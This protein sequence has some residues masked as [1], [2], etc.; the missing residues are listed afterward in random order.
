MTERKNLTIIQLK[1]IEKIGD[2][3]IP[4]L[5]FKAKDGETEHWYQCWRTSLF[6]A[7]K[8]GEMIDAE[9]E[10]KETEEY[11]TNRKIVQ[12]YVDGQPLGG[13]KVGQ[14]YR[15]KSPEELE[16]S[17]KSYALA[18][19]KDLAVSGTIKLDEIIKQSNVF[20]NWLKGNGDKPTETKQSKKVKPEEPKTE[21]EN[22]ESID[23]KALE[24]K[25]PGEFYQA[26]L[27]HLKLAKSKVD[28]EVPE[29]DLTNPDQCQKAWQQILAIYGH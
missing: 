29:Y 2:K 24:F 12:I 11:G 9:I 14:Y 16:L 8:Q 17:A 22:E 1:P 7:I 28:K 6:D 26:C 13:R 21:I 27:D 4:K 23:L 20:Y 19:A 3:Q 25:N 18:Y 15:G 10:I 5:S